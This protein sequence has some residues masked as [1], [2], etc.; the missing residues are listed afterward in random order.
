M[1]TLLSIGLTSGFVVFLTGLLGLLRVFAR[2]RINLPALCPRV[3]SA[4]YGHDTC[5]LSAA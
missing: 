4:Q 2:S 3:R 5:D 1:H